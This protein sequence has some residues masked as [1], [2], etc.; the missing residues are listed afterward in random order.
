MITPDGIQ[1]M[2]CVSRHII[3]IATFYSVQTHNAGELLLARR[4]GRLVS[5]CCIGGDSETEL[6]RKH[7]ILD[8]LRETG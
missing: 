3:I 5:G 2:S 4:S 1:V 8:L 7:Q 6:H